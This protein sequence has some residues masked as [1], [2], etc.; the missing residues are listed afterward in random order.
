M[1]TLCVM[2]ALHTLGIAAQINASQV[3][4]TYTSQHQ[5]FREDCV[6]QAFMVNLSFCVRNKYS[7]HTLG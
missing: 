7:K 6:N 4:V 5:L 3:Q 2:T 1:A